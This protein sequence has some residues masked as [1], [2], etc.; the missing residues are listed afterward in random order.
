MI[1]TPGARILRLAFAI[2][3]LGGSALRADDAEGPTDE[4]TLV[5]QYK[6]ARESHDWVQL[7]AVSRQLLALRPKSWIYMRGIAESEFH[8]G[9]YQAAAVDYKKAILSSSVLSTAMA[10]KASSE[11]GVDLGDSLMKLKHFDDAM[12]AYSDAATSSVDPGAIYFT[13]CTV[14][15]NNGN[16]DYALQFADKTIVSSPKNADAYFI[17]GAVQVSTW[18]AK[19][20]AGGALAPGTKEALQK[21]LELTPSGA[22]A[23]EAK[24][25][26][27][28][29]D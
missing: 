11:M 20:D 29:L 2:A 26:L 24:Q 1:V 27:A 21:Y 19:R 10:R 5:G 28:A 3:L 15:Y 14:M 18:A 7:G 23:E 9:D 22:H 16:L 8:A 17:K 13:I 25:M 12:A 4:A 6:A